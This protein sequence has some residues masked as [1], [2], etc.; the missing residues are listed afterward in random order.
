[1]NSGVL[2]P[3]VKLAAVAGVVAAAAIVA[4]APAA[5]DLGVVVAGAVSWCLWL[6]RHPPAA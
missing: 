1:M 4:W 5:V 3:A 6:E 2:V